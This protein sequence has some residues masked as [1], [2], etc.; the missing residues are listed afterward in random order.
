MTAR[1]FADGYATAWRAKAGGS[2]TMSAPTRPI[3]LWR[4]Q[5]SEGVEGNKAEGNGH[6]TR[7]GM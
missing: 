6:S 7:G 3:G 5:A 4:P 2:Q 1:R